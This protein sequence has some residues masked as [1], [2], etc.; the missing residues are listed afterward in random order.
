VQVLLCGCCVEAE[1]EKRR[2]GE[3]EEQVEEASSPLL[4]RA[5]LT[6]IE[7]Q[8]STHDDNEPHPNDRLHIAI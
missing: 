1:K 8:L 3:R 7:S 4:L 5:R 2:R 6:S